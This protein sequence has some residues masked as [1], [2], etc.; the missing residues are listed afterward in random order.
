METNELKFLLKLLGCANYRSSLVASGFRDYKGKDKICLALGDRELVDYSREIAAVKILPPGQAL[1]QVDASELPIAAK[2]LKVL[3]KIAKAEKIKPSEIKSPPATE[4]DN[5]LQALAKRGLIEVEMQRKKQ[6]AEVW[7]T[8]RGLEYLRDEYSATGKNPTISLELLSNYLTF[9]RKSL[10]VETDQGSAAPMITGAIPSDEEILQIIRNLDK[11]LGTENYLPIFH[12][13]QKLQPPLS[14]E[15]LD[16][17]LYHLQ[18]HDDIELSSLVDP[19]PYTAA[20]IDAGIPQD[21]G[22]ALFFI[23][24]N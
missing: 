20:Q 8:Q 22:G 2:E 24:V 4:R 21:V 1:L 6:N 5:I 18:R 23:V 7:L 13:R 12:L 17:V 14:R 10:R 16:R 3:Q 9:L 15:Q 11:E 19:T